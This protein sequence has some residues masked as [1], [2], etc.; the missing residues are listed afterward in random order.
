MLKRIITNLYEKAIVVNNPYYY[1]GVPKDEYSKKNGLVALPR[2]DV[3][4]SEADA[5]CVVKGYPYAVKIK[6]QLGGRFSFSDGKLFLKIDSLTFCVN[7]SEELFIVYEVFSLLTYNYSS[8]RDTVV[9]DV[10]M[11]AAITSLFFATNPLVKKIFAYELFSPTFA[12][13]QEN[14]SLNPEYANKIAAFNFG[15]SDR[16]FDTKL[17]YSLS[18]K[19]R[20]GLKGLPQNEHF[21]D[22]TMQEVTVK[23]IL[24][25]FKG[26]ISA[27]PGMNIVAKIDCEGEEFTLI[28]RLA[29]SGFLSKLDVVM[30]EWH[31]TNAKE[32]V[33]NLIAF[34]FHVFWSR[35]PEGDSG[36]IY[37]SRNAEA[38]SLKSEP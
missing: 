21:T 24:P 14:L 9:I 7:S 10:G 27:C 35:M 2:I 15:L 20:M 34:H 12:L 36:M 30:I 11:N 38:S 16:D 13:A 17:N 29:E 3:V 37:A 6:E 32:M 18:Q 33:D 1:Y 5:A 31:G 25:V 23:D 8:L 4:L 28:R 19:G 22:V 26:I